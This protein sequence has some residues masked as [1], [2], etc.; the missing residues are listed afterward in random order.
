MLF[1]IQE[2]GARIQDP[3]GASKSL[4]FCAAAKADLGEQNANMEFESYVDNQENGDDADPCPLPI[5]Y[6]MH[7]AQLNSLQ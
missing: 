6:T 2:F 7:R 5:H 1:H 4:L 3:D